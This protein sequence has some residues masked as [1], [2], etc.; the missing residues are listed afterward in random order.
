[1]ESF[2]S[3]PM[4]PVSGVLLAP[5]VPVTCNMMR[6]KRQLQFGFA[7]CG[8]TRLDACSARHLAALA[9]SSRSNHRAVEAPQTASPRMIDVL[10]MIWLVGSKACKKG[11]WHLRDLRCSAGHSGGHWVCAYLG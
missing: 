2:R 11:D 3:T 10:G 1:M 6:V 5:T 8:R 7:D 4:D 9:A